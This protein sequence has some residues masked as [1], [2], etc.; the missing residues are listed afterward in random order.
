MKRFI[1]KTPKL[2]FGALLAVT[3]FTCSTPQHSLESSP[4]TALEQVG[5]M[6]LP[7]P[8]F[9]RIGESSIADIAEGSVASVVNISS[10]KVVKSR[11]HQGFGPFSN[12][13]FFRHFFGDRFDSRHL[14]RERRERSLGSGVIV[15]SKGIILTNNHVI[16]KAQDITVTLSDGRDFKA[17]IVGSDPES[18][19]GVLQLRGDV[20]GLKPIAYG[21]SDALR[22]GD[23]VLAIGNPFGVGQTV[24]MG[25]VSAKGRADVGIVDYEDFIQTDAAINPGNSGGALVDMQ[26]KLVG[27]NTAILS[28][29]GGYQ[30][31]GF[32]I[33]S[34]MA[35]RVADSLQSYGKVV[36]GW[37]GV[38][39]QDIDQ[40]LADALGLSSSKGV[41]IGDVNVGGPADKG[42]MKRGDVVLRING[43]AVNST[44][45]LRNM[46]ANAGARTQVKIELWRDGTKH[47]LNIKLGKKAGHQDAP[48]VIDDQEATLDGLSLAPLNEDHRLKLRLPE[49]VKSGV[50]VIG[51]ERGSLAARAGLRTG[52]VIRE[53]NRR[54]VK[55]VKDFK[56]TYKKA[57]GTLALLVQRGAN[58]LYLAFRKQ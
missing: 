49:N 39:I 14:P 21:D 24:T 23:V 25:I 51:V 3:A 12:D 28:R 32:A 27:I 22:L 52:D 4:P 41:L 15:D 31:I 57:K 50:V 13:P 42:G 44:G 47:T 46:V 2:F 58:T 40:H 34:N 38:L 17:D 29:T 6:L 26:G 7:A 45:K 18:D 56:K 5:R 55:S 36:R 20:E 33:P 1:R 19:L 53:L 30:G 10:E 54:S 35:S 48:Q 37:L 8:A 11:G 43:Q 16:A 9:A